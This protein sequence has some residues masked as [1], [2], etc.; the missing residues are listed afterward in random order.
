MLSNMN[1]LHRA[2]ESK[3]LGTPLTGRSESHWSHYFTS[4]TYSVTTTENEGLLEVTNL[5][6]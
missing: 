2:M 1:S 6:V 5:V 4:G 3:A